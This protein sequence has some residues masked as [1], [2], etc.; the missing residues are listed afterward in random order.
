MVL[1]KIS[2]LACERYFVSSHPVCVG[3]EFFL[4]TLHT[5]FYVGPH[6]CSDFFSNAL[7]TLLLKN[8]EVLSQLSF[9]RDTS[10]Y[11]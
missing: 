1:I 10:S 6:D 8:N 11:T 2:F 9:C 7:F 4:S 3:S 5:C